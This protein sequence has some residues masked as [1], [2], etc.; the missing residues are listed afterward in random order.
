MCD[1]LSFMQFGN[2]LFKKRST[3]RRKRRRKG[4]RRDGLKLLP[5]SAKQVWDNP[6]HVEIVHHTIS[7]LTAL[8]CAAFKYA[9]TQLMLPN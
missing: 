5:V 3:R 2:T 1:K 7:A 9:G 6:A 8:K 4:R